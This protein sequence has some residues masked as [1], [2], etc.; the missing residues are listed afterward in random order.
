MW[1]PTGRREGAPPREPSNGLLQASSTPSTLLPHSALRRPAS[2][3]QVCPKPPTRAPNDY[4]R[5][6]QQPNRRGK[7][8]S[9]LVDGP[10]ETVPTRAPLFARFH[11]LV[12]Y[13]ASGQ[14][15]KIPDVL[16]P[17]PSV[18]YGTQSAV[19]TQVRHTPYTSRQAIFLSAS[20]FHL[21]HLDSTCECYPTKKM[22][23]PP[24]WCCSH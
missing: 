16:Q 1:E 10:L 11:S 9:S 17:R 21:A 15:W 23:L 19:V 12:L 4:G 22:I 3:M 20:C 14:N 2:P 18:S 13:P 7:K 6:P 5:C 8:T 24:S